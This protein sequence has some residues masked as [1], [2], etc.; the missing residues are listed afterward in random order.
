MFSPPILITLLL[1]SPLSFLALL[2][3]HPLSQVWS[4]LAATRLNF[5]N[6]RSPIPTLQI[7][8]PGQRGTF[9]SLSF[10]SFFHFYLFIFILSANSLKIVIDVAQ[11]VDFIISTKGSVPGAKLVVLNLHDPPNVHGMWVRLR[12]GQE[13]AKE[14]ELT[15]INSGS[16]GM[17]DVHYRIGV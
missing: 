9:F 2:G 14:E 13:D 7:G 11:L 3:P 10:I 12:R 6:A 16:N 4:V 5:Q 17:W 15:Q 1:V 8:N